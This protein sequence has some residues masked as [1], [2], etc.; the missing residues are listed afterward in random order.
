VPLTKL[1]DLLAEA[2]KT[3]PLRVAVAAA[4]GIEV[5]TAL[6]EAEKEKIVESILIG[7]KN[8]ILSICSEIDFKPHQIIHE[9]DK[10]K[11]SYIAVQL[12]KSGEAQLIMKGKMETVDLLKAVLDK[13]S[14]LRQAGRMLSQVVVFEAPGFNRLML[15]TDTSV[16]ISPTLLDKAEICKNVIRVAHSIGFE[17]P[18][19]AALA[20][21]EFVNPAIPS[22][23]DAACLTQMN[24][25]GQI[26]GA[27]IDGP[28]ALD[29]CL[30]YKAAEQKGIQ[31][32]VAGEA[33]ILVA[34]NLDAAN[35]LYRSIIYF[36]EVRNC[37]LVTGAKVPLIL[38]SRAESADTKLHSI[39]LSKIMYE[40]EKT[41][42][43]I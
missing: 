41:E 5:L 35:I 4:Q 21:L 29:A 12:I 40:F 28:L 25:R 7:D 34:P 31:S 20:T 18:K 8:A 38:L 1:D 19:L 14:G 24:R 30:S 16:N 37:G 10:R 22:T 33:D 23:I 15:L 27:I 42:G 2:K 13:D 3:G 32:P 26:T 11:C 36:N 6:R 9:E 39:A 17:N 43:L